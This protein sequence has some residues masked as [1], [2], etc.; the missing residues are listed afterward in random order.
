M[1][2][3]FSKCF[4]TNNCVLL[5]RLVQFADKQASVL[6]DLDRR[7]AIAEY[8]DFHEP[9]HQYSK[10]KTEL[11]LNLSLEP[12]LIVSSKMLTLSFLNLKNK[13]MTYALILLSKRHF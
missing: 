1:F 11:Q 2:L 8:G 9:I 6:F 5:I 4:K 3:L 7:L 13:I 12:Q 10:L